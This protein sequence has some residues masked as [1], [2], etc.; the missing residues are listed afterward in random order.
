MPKLSPQRIDDRKWERGTAYVRAV[1]EYKRILEETGPFSKET[2][3]AYRHMSYAKRQFD[4][5]RFL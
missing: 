1:G 5:V 2:L 4:K 3:E